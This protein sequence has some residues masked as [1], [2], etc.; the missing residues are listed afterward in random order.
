MKTT[1]PE[2]F[3]LFTPA[4]GGGTASPLASLETGMESDVL[5]CDAAGALVYV[6]A[7]RQRQDLEAAAELRGLCHWADLHRVA[8]GRELVEGAIDPALL[9]TD[10]AEHD[11][12]VAE[13]KAR[14]LGEPVPEWATERLAT[15][16]SVPGELG[17]EGQLRLDGQ[18]CFMVGEFAI[19]HLATELGLSEAAARDLV[20]QSVELRDRLPRLW[21]RVMGRC[22]AG[23]E[24]P[25]DRSEDDSLVG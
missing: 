21:G 16:G 11:A 10:R 3:E 24:G 15:R 5:G 25:P 8:P 18:G 9:A 23:V 13:A 6:V 17:T 4:A 12:R 20:G 2:P 7:R 19:T 14:L 22:A 1:A